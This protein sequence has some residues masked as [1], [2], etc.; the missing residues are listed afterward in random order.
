MTA[1]NRITL[2]LATL[3]TA[4]FIVN[5]LSVTAQNPQMED[6]LLT[7]KAAMDN[8]KLKLAKYTWQETEVISVKGDVKD[9]KTFQVQIVNG[10]QQ[11]NLINDQKAQPSGRVGRVK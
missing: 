8:N 5:G 11:K 1:A 7:I 10:Q 2:V 3:A 6:K 9:T 4:L